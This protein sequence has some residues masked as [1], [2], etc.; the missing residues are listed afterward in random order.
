MSTN[1]QQPGM[2]YDYTAPANVASGEVVKIG[3]TL[4]VALSPITSGSVGSV[5][6]CGV[7][8]VPKVSAAVIAQGDPVVF[9]NATKSF[10]AKG[11]TTAAGDV[12]GA[13]AV[14]FEAAGAGV[15]SIAIRFTGVPGTVI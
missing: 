8:V 3:S 2:V 4:G 11:A 5:Y 10:D 7:F 6:T 9:K 15:T 14:A 12:T 13:S 1:F